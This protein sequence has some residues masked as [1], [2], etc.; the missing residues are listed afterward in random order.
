MFWNWKEPMFGMVRLCLLLHEKKH[1]LLNNSSFLMIGSDAFFSEPR[2]VGELMENL[3][4]DIASECL[5]ESYAV[6]SLLKTRE[7]DLGLPEGAIY[8]YL[9]DR[10]EGLETTL[11]TYFASLD[12][13]VVRDI[14]RYIDGHLG[15]DKLWSSVYLRVRD[16]LNIVALMQ[17]YVHA[18]PQISSSKTIEDIVK[19][20]TSFRDVWQEIERQRGLINEGYKD[21]KKAMLN[22]AS[23]FQQLFLRL[24]FKLSDGPEGLVPE[25]V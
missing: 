11:S 23:Y 21:Y 1:I 12:F 18:T 20:T 4:D 22:L 10:Q 19:S 15:M 7:F 17:A 25:L 13:V 24:G 16:A 8:R 2:S 14:Q 3:A 9:C 5:A 6:E